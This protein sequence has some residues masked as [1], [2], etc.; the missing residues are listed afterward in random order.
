MFPANTWVF[1]LEIVNAIPTRDQAF[2]P[3]IRYCSGWG[4]HA[5][6]GVSVLVAARIDGSDKRIFIGANV[7]S[8]VKCSFHWL[9]AFNDI[10]KDADCLVGYASRSFDAKV[11]AAKGLHIPESK[12]VDLL[13]EIKK[14]L[15]NFAPKGYKLNDVSVR[16]GGP[17][18]TGDGA[19]V[20]IWW[21][22]G[23]QQRVIDYCAVDIG[24]TCA[25]AQFYTRNRAC[26][27]DPKGG[28]I[29]LRVP[30]TIFRE[31]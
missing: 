30:E 26:L 11:L 21:Q 31:G 18:K 12:H 23:E 9:G 19:D 10:I 3:G 4:D 8:D 27:P 24:A 25:I 1:D 22:R 15:N 17:M 14:S 2:L 7:T 28:L 13:W 29:Q 5:G 6:M 16:C 20:P